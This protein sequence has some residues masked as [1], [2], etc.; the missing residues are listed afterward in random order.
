MV[1]INCFSKFRSKVL[2]FAPLALTFAASSLFA[3]KPQNV[4]LICVDDL[5][6]ELSCYGA[7]YIHSPNIDGLASQGILFER[8]YVQAPTCGASRYA[9]LT[10]KYG[11]SNNKALFERAAQMGKDPASVTPSLPAWFGKHGYETVAVGKVSHHPGGR[12]GPDWNDST[13]PELPQAWDRSLMPSG[14][15]QHPRGAMHGLANGEIR[16]K[17]DKMAVYQSFEGPDTA[18]PDGLITGSALEEIETLAQGDKPF[19]LAVGLIR[20]HL[21]FGA[22]ARY[23]KPYEQADLPPVPHPEKPEGIT[24]WHPSGEFKRYNHWGRDANSDKAFSRELRR[25]YAACVSY[26][27]AQ[28]GRLLEKLESLDLDEDTIVVVWGDHG[29]HL[30]EH[31]VWGKHTLFE[32]SLRSPLIMRYPG[33]ANPGKRLNAIV[34]T[35]D[36]YPTLCDLS[37]IPKPDSIDGQSLLPGI[38]NP[39]TSSKMAISYTRDE[40]TL[41]TDTHRL[42]IHND[43][44]AELYSHESP[45]KETRNIAREN[46]EKVVSMA[47]EIHELAPVK[48]PENLL[49]AIREKLESPPVFAGKS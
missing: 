7:D 45:E 40:V 21:P 4:L 30:G 23:M 18:Y 9:L 43:G 1:M 17:T 26:A 37:G 47:G 34:E 25:H 36:L 39:D 19:F 10:G 16:N 31:A 24:T 48:L 27:D 2:C 41:R 38:D 46:P 28:V 5:R 32:E 14:A 12:G 44:Y 11:P 8:H 33:H 29:W 42:I 6:P 20:P 3:E 15:W 13:Q 49:D 22:P 35:I